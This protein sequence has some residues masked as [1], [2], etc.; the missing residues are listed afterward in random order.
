MLGVQMVPGLRIGRLRWLKHPFISSTRPLAPQVAGLARRNATA[1][2]IGFAYLLP[3]TEGG[4]GVRASDCVRACW[5][6]VLHV[7]KRATG[8]WMLRNR[9]RKRATRGV[10]RFLNARN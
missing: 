7:R 9:L 3:C 1:T 10:L 6:P 2:A 8:R 5:L 4:P